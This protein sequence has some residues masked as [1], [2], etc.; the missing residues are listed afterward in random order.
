MLSYFFFPYFLLFLLPVYFMRSF[1]IFF[2]L[3]HSFLFHGFPSFYP[4]FF[5]HSCFF[6]SLLSL[7]FFSFSLS[8]PFVLC[9]LVSLF[10]FLPSFVPVFLLPSCLSPSHIRSCFMDSSLFLSFPLSFL[11]LSSVSVSIFPFFSLFSPVSHSVF[12]FAIR[13]C[14]LSFF[15]SFSNSFLLRSIVNRSRILDFI[16]H[17]RPA[18][19]S[20]PTIGTCQARLSPLRCRLIAYRKKVG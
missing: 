13:P 6:H 12:L 1:L 4:F 2:F 15:I 17:A 14:L 3:S 9:V 18:S 19:G 20:P 5:I 16:P 8:L 7:L 11:C 10:C